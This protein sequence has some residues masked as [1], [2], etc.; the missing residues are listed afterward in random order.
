VPAN[1]SRYDGSTN[2]CVWLEDYRL[3]CRI[4]GIKDD[5]LVIQFLPTHLVEGARAWLKHL[6]ADTI[7]D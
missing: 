7:R 1:I 2:P 6:P 4:A 5:H 3:A